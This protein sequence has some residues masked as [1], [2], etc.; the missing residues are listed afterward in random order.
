MLCHIPG[1]SD[2]IMVN[3]LFMSK[4]DFFF[5]CKVISSKLTHK[6]HDVVLN[7][8]HPSPFTNDYDFPH[9]TK[10]YSVIIGN[11]NC[12]KK[13]KSFVKRDRWQTFKTTSWLLCVSF[14]E[15]ALQKKKK[16]TSLPPKLITT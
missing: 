3:S 13:K 12:K 9:A 14:K 1:F 15:M 11:N 10:F 6:N 16:R 8:F 2:K 5:F 7:V 4:E